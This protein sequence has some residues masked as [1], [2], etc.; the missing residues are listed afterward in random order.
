MVYKLI[1][2]NWLLIVYYGGKKID[3][4]IPQESVHGPTFYIVCNNK[5]DRQ[6]VKYAN[7]T[8]LLYSD[9]IWESVHTKTMNSLNKV[10]RLLA[11]RKLL[12][13]IKNTFYMTFT[14]N[15]MSI[16]LNE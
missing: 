6:I 14:L 16:S 9:K 8:H 13:N 5:I 1:E 12:L 7:D 3:Y 10:V 4:N 11:I 15:S 2:Y